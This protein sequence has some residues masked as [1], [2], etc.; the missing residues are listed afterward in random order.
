MLSFIRVALVM[1]SL[2]SNKTLT[3]TP[4]VL[5]QTGYFQGYFILFTLMKTTPTF[6]IKHGEVELVP[7]LEASLLSSSHGTGRYSVCY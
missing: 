2:H 4:A 7:N 3:M 1:V 5:P 6:E